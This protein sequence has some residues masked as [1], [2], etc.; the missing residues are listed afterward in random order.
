MKMYAKIVKIAS[1]SIL[2]VLIAVSNTNATPVAKL[3]YG[4]RAKKI[5]ESAYTFL[6]TRKA[7]SLDA[8]TVSEDKF[9]KDDVIE[10]VK[11]IHIDLQRP[12]RLRVSSM[13]EFMKR[14][15]YLDGKEFIIYDPYHQLYGKIETKNGIDAT[16][17]YLYEKYGIVSPLANLLYSDLRKRVMPKARG[18]YLGRR[19]VNGRWCHYLLFSDSEKEFQVWIRE[20]AVPLIEKFTLIDKSDPLRLHSST[21]IR[22]RLE[23]PKEEI[24]HFPYLQEASEI[25]VK[26]PN[27][28]G[29]AR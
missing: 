7:F 9:K 17:D 13:D 5:L 2:S 25:P 11:K 18:Y 14:I 6:E 12:G 20:G 23:R 24:F 29:V 16:L 26:V 19:Q 3:I 28:K 15:Y 4:D 22:W 1:L 10:V 21:T 8:L 27:E